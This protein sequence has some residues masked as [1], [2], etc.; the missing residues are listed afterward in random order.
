MAIKK[1][2]AVLKHKKRLLLIQVKAVKNGQKWFCAP[3]FW[4]RVR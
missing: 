4:S 1:N 2:T 3:K